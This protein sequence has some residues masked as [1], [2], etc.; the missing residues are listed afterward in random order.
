MHS[1]VDLF[2]HSFIESFIDDDDAGG[3]GV[4]VYMVG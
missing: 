2:L 4:Y 1:F 3:D